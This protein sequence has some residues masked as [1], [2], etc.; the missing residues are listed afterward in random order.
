MYSTETGMVKVT[1]FSFTLILYSAEQERIAPRLVSNSNS[2]PPA[3]S[4]RT[5]P[6]SGSVF[7]E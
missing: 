2:P 6:S 1:F 7:I 4:K 5:I 3:M